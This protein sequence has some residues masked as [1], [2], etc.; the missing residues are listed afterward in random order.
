M[1]R[2]PLR[3]GV[4]NRFLCP[5]SA[6]FPRSVTY[7]MTFLTPVPSISISSCFSS[8]ANERDS[9]V[10]KSASRGFFSRAFRVPAV[11]KKREIA[12]D[13]HGGGVHDDANTVG[14]APSAITSSAAEE[15]GWQ[16]M[17]EG[18]KGEK[19]DLSAGKSRRAVGKNLGVPGGDKTRDEVGG[20][21]GNGGQEE[22][23]HLSRIDACQA[24]E[25]GG[26]KVEGR[27][28]QEGSGGGRAAKGDEADVWW[29]WSTRYPRH[30]VLSIHPPSAEGIDGFS[31]TIPGGRVKEEGD[32]NIEEKTNL[33]LSPVSSTCDPTGT[34]P[35]AHQMQDLAPSENNNSAS[36][37]SSV[38]LNTTEL[39]K[40]FLFGRLFLRP[41]HVA[42][43]LTV[44]EGWQDCVCI[45][46]DHGTV[47]LRKGVNHS[48]RGGAG[49][50]GAG[51]EEE[52][53]GKH[54][55]QKQEQERFFLECSFTAKQIPEGDPHSEGKEA[56]K[57][58]LPST[59][60]PSTT[61]AGGADGRGGLSFDPRERH[62]TAVYDARGLHHVTINL[63]EVS[64]AILLREHLESVLREMFQIAFR[65]HVGIAAR[66]LRR[67]REHPR[68]TLS[69]S[70]LSTGRSNRG[71]HGASSMTASTSHSLPP[72]HH[73]HVAKHHH[74]H[75]NNILRPSLPSVP[76]RYRSQIASLNGDNGKAVENVLST[77]PH[78]KPNDHLN[79][80]NAVMDD[81]SGASTDINHQTDSVSLL[82]RGEYE[83][84]SVLLE[85]LLRDDDNDDDA[86]ELSLSE[87]V[88]DESFP[89]VEKGEEEVEVVVEEEEEEEE[90]ERL[91]NSLNEESD[92]EN[93]SP[94]STPAATPTTV[95]AAV[96]AEDG[97][98]EAKSSEMSSGEGK[99]EV[100]L[101]VDW[102]KE[103]SDDANAT[104]G[105]SSSSFGISPPSTTM[106]TSGENTMKTEEEKKKERRERRKQRKLEKERLEAEKKEQ[107]R[108]L[109][110]L[111]RQEK[112]RM[113][114][115]KKEKESN[116]LTTE[117]PKIDPHTVFSSSSSSHAVLMEKSSLEKD[118]EQEEIKANE[119]EEKKGK[120]LLSS[121]VMTA[122]KEE[123]IPSSSPSS[124]NVRSGK[125]AKGNISERRTGE[126]EKSPSQRR[127]GSD[128]T[129][130]QSI[131]LE[132]EKDKDEEG[133]LTTTIT[134][135]TASP[136]ST[137]TSTTNNNDSNTT[138]GV[139]VAHNATTTTTSGTEND[140]THMANGVTAAAACVPSSS[141]ST[142][143]SPSLDPLSSMEEAQEKQIAEQHSSSF[144]NGTTS[145][146][147]SGATTTRASTSS[148]DGERNHLHPN[149]S[150]EGEKNVGNSHH[151]TQDSMA[152]EVTKGVKT[153]VE[154][155]PSSSESPATSAVNQENDWSR[156]KKE[157]SVKEDAYSSP[158][159]EGR[160]E[161][162]KEIRSAF[163]EVASPISFSSTLAT[164]VPPSCLDLLE[165]EKKEKLRAAFSSPPQQQ[166]QPQEQDIKA[167][168]NKKKEEEEEGILTADHS[169]NCINS[170]PLSMTEDKKGERG[171]VDGF[172]T[173]GKVAAPFASFSPNAEVGKETEEEKVKNP[174][175][176]KMERKESASEKKEVKG[177]ENK[178][179]EAEPCKEEGEKSADMPPTMTTSTTNVTGGS[180]SRE[181]SSVFPSSS[182]SSQEEGKEAATP[183]ASESSSSS[184]TSTKDDDG[185][186][187][188]PASFSSP[189]SASAVVE[190]KDCSI[191]NNNNNNNDDGDAQHNGK[192][193]HLSTEEGEKTNEDHL[194]DNKGGDH[195]TK[196]A[197]K[198]NL[199][200]NSKDSD[201]AIAK[202]KKTKS[203]SRK[204]AARN[205]QEE[206]VGGN[207]KGGAGKIEDKRTLQNESSQEINTRLSSTS[208]DTLRQGY[209]M[210]DRENN[211]TNQHDP[212]TPSDGSEAKR[213]GRSTGPKK[214]GPNTEKRPSNKRKSNRKPKKD[215]NSVEEKIIL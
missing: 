64:Q 129:A 95:T 47:T 128:A 71:K 198:R 108:Q 34:G 131:S 111:K 88:K 96:A 18:M 183:T 124:E 160:K 153:E 196:K 40:H 130:E 53:K 112:K 121:S 75:R 157:E 194:E 19:T 78:P 39:E 80:G 122:G 105:V 81:R 31:R 27:L 65:Y 120:E 156:R 90:I 73:R 91:V 145:R 30:L 67:Q 213:G 21:G 186:G 84:E 166:Q 58:P 7:F 176:G 149:G 3:Y 168:E 54:E 38:S 163:E 205:A 113:E 98:P 179:S 37:S 146:N 201:E 140:P 25:K 29:E 55:K 135:N 210:N 56:E 165:K 155:A 94:L 151:T 172:S 118:E 188:F 212:H 200:H 173:A 17:G 10:L 202:S 178:V 195:Q 103:L 85:D 8:C 79:I 177:V 24:L 167:E 92:S 141:F 115:E 83:E 215:K 51:G 189:T 193:V 127:A 5:C 74:R 171:K 70:S 182:S 147:I 43:L 12:V 50:K 206:E 125:V 148:L 9:T 187:S 52:K 203:Q 136:M 62:P 214:K 26:V 192:K 132:G 134:N 2:F 59:S 63:T 89:I 197:S 204:N 41:Y 15:R 109:R 106:K 49:K 33:D 133:G 117:T 36:S 126:E 139:T 107:K 97:K 11:I 61:S 180:E 69:P 35:T 138:S 150:R 154:E 161:E 4:R 44:L 144:T 77:N 13:G 164:E 159:S 57:Q 32:G 14:A 119:E 158:P 20:N 42:Q 137:S 110:A 86:D 199:N 46:R 184:N 191:N 185:S 174:P 152:D 101:E 211:A 45:Q 99:E 6:P 209:R 170:P 66:L 100:E 93:I 102:E 87:K 28:E 207:A 68:S 22:P 48:T 181:R 162:K 208:G 76:P 1:W 60:S 143:S 169:P 142:P 114:Q 175:D 116:S 123:S 16:G 82:E 72:Y 23:H 190:N 104:D